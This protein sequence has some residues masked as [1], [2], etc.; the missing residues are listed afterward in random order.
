MLHVV[1]SAQSCVPLRPG[2]GHQTLF[3]SVGALLLL[4]TSLAG[5]P[6]VHSPVRLTLVPKAAWQRTCLAFWDSTAQT[7]SHSKHTHQPRVPL[8]PAA[9]R[10]KLQKE[11]GDL[12]DAAGLDS[13]YATVAP[14]VIG[15]MLHQTAD[16]MK[17]AH[18]EKVTN[19]ECTPLDRLP[20]S[21]APASSLGLAPFLHPVLLGRIPA[22]SPMLV[23]RVSHTS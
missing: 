20:C 23:Q 16:A 15:E 11:Q 19:F 18:R 4:A 12:L 3:G 21:A 10:R 2:S 14:L 22:V 1:I 9:T 6:G 7:D 5:N 8:R 13:T 17:V